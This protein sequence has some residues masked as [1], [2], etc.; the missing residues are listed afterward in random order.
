[1][2][3]RHLRYFVAVAEELHFTRAAERLHIGQPPL[4]QQIQ[5]LEQELGVE[6]LARSK[7]RVSLTEAGKRFLVSA[8]RILAEADQAADDARRAARG[9]LGELRIGFSSSV[10]FTSMLPRLLHDYRQAH[11]QVTLTLRE[12]FA[13]EQME[14]LRADKLDIGLV[15]HSGLE[16]PADLEFHEIR[17]DPL[18]V[19]INAGHPL[20]SRAILQMSDLRDE[21]F[22]G[23][24]PGTGSGF[25]LQ[26]HRL[27]LAAGFAPRVVQEAREITTQIGL[28][29]A[30]LGIAV[31][32]A[33]FECI[34][35]D[36]VRYVPLADDG[37]YLALA[38]ATRRLAPS[39]LVGGFLESLWTLTAST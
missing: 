18:R 35:I 34:K 4:S 25:T 1:M 3:L 27:C 21:G 23:Y 24:P 2:E 19:A 39:P 7:R 32:P 26:L 37:A 33:P 28:A 31:L 20:A 17:Q 9:E 15:R 12:M 8:R 6:L 10:P 29:A 13:V 5:A 30:G 16:H 22:I 38:V 14:A 36:G 11:P